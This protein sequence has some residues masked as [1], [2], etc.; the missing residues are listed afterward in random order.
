VTPASQPGDRLKALLAR[1]PPAPTYQPPRPAAGVEQLLD[2]SAEI[3]DARAL[4]RLYRERSLTET[5]PDAEE[6]TVAPAPIWS[7]A[8]GTPLAIPPPIA[9]RPPLSPAEI[10]A[11]MEDVRNAFGGG[12]YSIVDRPQVV[13]EPVVSGDPDVSNPP[14]A[15]GGDWVY[16]LGALLALLV[17]G[18]FIYLSLYGPAPFHRPPPSPSP[19]IGA[20]PA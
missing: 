6:E 18:G 13:D 16:Y 1:R 11:V 14:D 17:V 12:G 5:V 7:G 4:A 20:R 9:D 2:R 10:R 3:P 19:S 8:P 15:G